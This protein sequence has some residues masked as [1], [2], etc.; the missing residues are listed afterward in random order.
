MYIYIYLDIDTDIDRDVAMDIDT[1]IDKDMIRAP[2]YALCLRRP[3]AC[4][5]EGDE[6]RIPGT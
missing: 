4:R 3:T 1:D 5:S 2:R 6:L